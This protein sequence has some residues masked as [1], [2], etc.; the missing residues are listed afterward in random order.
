MDADTTADELSKT[1][2]SGE[3]V[4]RDHIPTVNLRQ[5]WWKPLT[6]D[7]PATPEPACSSPIPNGRMP[8]NILN[9]SSRL[10][11]TPVQCE[12]TTYHWVVIWVIV[13]IQPTSSSNK[14]LNIYGTVRKMAACLVNLEFEGRLLPYDAFRAIGTGNRCGL[15][16]NAEYVIAVIMVYLTGGFQRTLE[17][18]LTE[19][20]KVLTTV[21]TYVK[22]NLVIRHRVETSSWGL[23]ANQM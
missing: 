14:D 9:R 8:Q 7:R 4:G 23:R 17:P 11:A 16:K 6:E 18:S 3:D 21:V 15:K 2:Y 22:R 5:S 20:E 12:Q 13:T 19:D 1:Q 10:N